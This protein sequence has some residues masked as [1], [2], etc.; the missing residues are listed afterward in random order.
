MRLLLLVLLPKRTDMDSFELS[1]LR[2]SEEEEWPASNS[3]TVASSLTQADRSYVDNE[4]DAAA[5]ATYSRIIR[6][7]F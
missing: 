1:V 2:E 4:K 6:K 5:D 7:I 3:C